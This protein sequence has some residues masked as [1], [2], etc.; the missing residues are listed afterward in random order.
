MSLLIFKAKISW[1]WF[2]NKTIWLI[3]IAVIGGVLK[4][5]KI[6]DELIGWSILLILL[7]VLI[8]DGLFYKSM[9][10][11]EDKLIINR[12]LVF[13]FLKPRIFSYMNIV[14]VIIYPKGSVASLPSMKIFF[15]DKTNQNKS[16]GLVYTLIDKKTIKKFAEILQSHQI[17][18]TV[19][20]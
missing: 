4:T 8:I 13:K 1:K 17:K 9:E 6:F 20:E 12:P 15:M 3:I 19:K 10:L 11:Y 14:E 2:I 7:F 16:M 18:V 5:G